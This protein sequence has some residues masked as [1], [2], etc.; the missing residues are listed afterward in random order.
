MK[1]RQH[2]I[3]ALSAAFLLVLL[4]ALWI[5]F[6]PVQFGGQASYVIVSGNSMEPALYRGDLVV[7]RTAR[8]YAVG[9]V[10]TFRHP[11]VGP[12]IHRIIGREGGRFIFQGDNNEWVDSY[13]PRQEELIGKM[14][15]HLPSAGNVMEQLRTPTAMTVLAALTGFILISGLGSGSET[16]PRRKGRAREAGEQ[17]TM[18]NTGEHKGD[19]LFA[20]AALAFASLFLAGFAFTRPLTIS[21]PDDLMYE[22]K[23][24]FSYGAPAQAGLYD[25]ATVQAGEPLFP[26]LVKGL[27]VEFSYLLAADVP[28]DVEGTYRLT[29]QVSDS[30]GWKRTVELQPETPFTGTTFTAA[31]ELDLREVQRLVETFEKQTGIQRPQYVVAVIPE[32]TTSGSLGGQKLET[33]FAPRLEFLLDPFQLRLAAADGDPTTA[34]S[35]SQQGLL[36]R[37]RSESNTISIFGLALAVSTA[38]WL[39]IVGVLLALGAGAATALPLVRATRGDEPS[40]VQLKYGSMLINVHESAFRKDRKV[41]EV[42]GIEDLARL[43]EKAGCMILHQDRGATHHY[44]VQDGSVIYHY[45]AAAGSQELAT[46]PADGA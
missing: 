1:S 8:H 37:A 25:A 35:H 38:R 36:Q 44:Y 12:V 33:Q 23:G 16:R 2:T 41:I 42:L 10:V 22:Q 28:G 7:L 26:R 20:L 14:W 11:T 15:L 21:V 6:A 9:E 30:S 13:Q 17:R 40:R 3:Q 27:T 19:L 46:A 31:G 24:N 34:L 45:Q 5:T 43:A 4:G 32:V 18:S 39:S 29:G